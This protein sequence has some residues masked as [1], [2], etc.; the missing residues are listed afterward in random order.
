MDANG[1]G[2]PPS[3][4]KSDR[5]HDAG[6]GHAPASS[7][8]SRSAGHQNWGAR[9]AL[10][11]ALF[12]VC[13]GAATGWALSIPPKTDLAAWGKNGLVVSGLKVLQAYSQRLE[14]IRDQV[15]KASKPIPVAYSCTL[16]L[17]VDP[18]GG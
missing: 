12:G 5:Q 2:V 6:H 17:P 18:G 3:P 14:S 8:R 16:L 1:S 15:R 11:I 13:A 9:N 4:S 10:Q 7:H